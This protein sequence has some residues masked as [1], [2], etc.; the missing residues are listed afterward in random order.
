MRAENVFVGARV[1]DSLPFS[2]GGTAEEARALRA[3]GVEGLAGYLGAMNAARLA[4]ILDAGLGFMPVTYAGEYFDGPDDELAQLK[5]LGIPV[6]VTVWLD[7]EGEKSF[8]WDPVDLQKKIN[9]WAD[10]HSKAGF[11][12]AL[13]IG[14]PQPLTGDELARLR[15][16][17]YWCA[18][19]RVID[20]NGKVWDEPPGCGFCMRQQWPQGMWKDTG[21]FVDV[22]IVGQDRRKRVPTWVRA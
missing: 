4:Y 19:S 1:V 22:N 16:F 11:I 7:L 18:A 6:G 14:S 20:R 8:R 15:V 2:M 9:T 3:S 21:V 12:P 5:A 13:Y 17:R 10:A